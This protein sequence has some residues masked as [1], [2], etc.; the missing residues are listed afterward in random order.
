MAIGYYVKYV[1]K[2][3]DLFNLTFPSQYN[4]DIDFDPNLDNGESYMDNQ[5][6]FPDVGLGAYWK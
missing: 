6:G 5:L 2:G 1:Q 3:I 4:G